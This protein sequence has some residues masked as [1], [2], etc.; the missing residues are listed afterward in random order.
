MAT[1]PA[2][3]LRRI[4]VRAVRVPMRE[5]HQTA[6]GAVA[7]SPLVLTDACCASRRRRIGSSMPTGGIRSW[8]SRLPSRMA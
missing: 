2:P 1:D 6:S 5:P 8:R 4:T 3:K 7:E